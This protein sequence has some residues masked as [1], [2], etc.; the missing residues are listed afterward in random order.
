MTV[1]HN[2]AVIGAGAWGTALAQTAARAG[3]DVLLWARRKDVAIGIAARSE[4]AERL[5]GIRLLDTVKATHRLS[6]LGAADLVLSVAPAQHTRTLLIEA[7]P[8][9]KPEAPIVLCSKGVELVTRLFMSQVAAEI[10]PNRLAAV[11]SGP[12]FAREVAAGLPAAV[13]LA[14]TD[15]ERGAAIVQALAHDTFRPYLSTDVT[16]AEVGG[17]VKNVLAI[18][19]GIVSGR[20]L[21][22]SAHAAIV[23]RGLAEMTRLGLALGGRPE[24]IQ[25]LSGVGDLVL[26]CSNL[27]SRNMSLGHALGMDQRLGE[28]MAE[29]SEVTEGVASA[30]AICAIARAKGVEMP[31][32]EAVNA[33]LSGK[34][35]VDAAVNMLLARP[36]KREDASL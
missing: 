6:D 19:C 4:N 13:T 26:T 16:G 2:V 35:S 25:G 8:H 3:R 18:A 31:I 1:Y 24:T 36:L 14:C 17:A 27:T 30:P 21:G 11:L 29:R 34:V 32:C 12:G 28:I 10:A 20:R 33:I 9:L 7:L 5:P 23:T 22:Q 15:S